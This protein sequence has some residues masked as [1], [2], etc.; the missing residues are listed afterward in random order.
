MIDRC[1]VFSDSCKGPE[2][3]ET[4]SFRFTQS[5]VAEVVL[6]TMVTTTLSTRRKDG[7]LA[8]ALSALRGGGD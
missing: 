6:H 4:R 3:G 2:I 1:G 8:A 5:S 7:W